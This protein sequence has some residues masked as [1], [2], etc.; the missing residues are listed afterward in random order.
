MNLCR[1]IIILFLIIAVL[2]AFAQDYNESYFDH[3]TKADGLSNNNITGITQDKTGYIWMTTNYGLTRFDGNRF[4]QYHSTDDSLSPASENLTGITWLDDHRLAI[5]TNGLNIINTQTGER[6]NL[7][8]PY[9]RKQYLYKFNMTVGAKGDNKG[10]IYLLTRSGFY[11]FDK[12]YNLV[13]RFDYYSEQQVATE[14][15]FFGGK[16]LELDNRRFLIVSSSGLYAY[17]KEERKIEKMKPHDYPLLDEFLGYPNTAFEFF[18]QKAG[19][20]FIVRPGTD[21]LIYINTML[22][23]KV[24]SNLPFKNPV[25]NISWRS[26]L[27]NVNDT[28]FYI[29]CQF[30]GFYKV[31]FYPESGIIKFN[32]QKFFDAYSC[33]ALLKD[34]DGILWVATNKGLFRQNIQKQNVQFATFPLKPGN[35]VSSIIPSNVFVSQ[36]KIYAG[37]H[38]SG[39]LSLFDKKTFQFEKQIDVATHQHFTVQVNE[40]VPAGKEDILIS[41]SS[42]LY[43]LNQAT[44]KATPVIPTGWFDGEWTEDLYRDK[45]GIIWISASS[46]LF[47][48][49]TNNKTFRLLPVNSQLMLPVRFAEDKDGN[50]WMASHGLQRFNTSAQR[51]DLM[52][53]SF[54]FIKMPDRQVNT[55]LV[56]DENNVWFNSN[57]NGLIAYNITN[58]KFR[59]F[60][61]KDG[62]PDNNIASMIIINKKLWIASFSGLACM[63]LKT[64]EII[65]FG[66]EDGFPDM[67]ISIDTK[68]FYDSL[69]HQLYTCFYNAIVRFN[70]DN[71]LLKNSPPRLFIESVLING[72][73]A[74][75]L[76][77]SDINVSWRNNEM[78]IK[79]GSI[80][81]FDGSN[82]NFAYRI[83]KH[84]TTL[85]QQLGNQPSFSISNLSP[86]THVIQVKCSSLNNKWPEQVKEISV[87]VLP[88]FWMQDW[89]IMLMVL[90]IVAAVYFLVRWRIASIRKKEMEKT[91]IQKLKA[92]DYK[93]QFELEQIS[94]YFSSSL[95]GKKTEAEVLW[96]VTNNLM[97]KMNYED[98]IIYL[99][100]KEKT[101]MVQKAAYG[102]KGKPEIISANVFEVLPGQGIVGHVIETR[103]PVLI[104]D[105]R[106]DERYRIDDAFRL[107]EVCV[108]IIHNNELLGALDSE[109]SQPGYYGE[110]DIKILTTIAT[111]IGNKLKQ[112]ES[113]Q[114]LEVKQQELA[115]INEQL[116]AARLTALQAQMNP[117]FV[118]NALNS[119]KRMI[120]DGDNEKA[121]RYLSKFAQMIRM[122]LEQSKDT[123]VSLEENIRYLNSYLEMEQLRFDETFTYKIIVDENIDV[124]ET[125]FPSL[126]IQPLVE[127]AIWHGLMPAGSDKKIYIKFIQTQNRIVCIIEDNGI[128]IG[129]SESIKQKNKSTHRSVGLENLQKRIKIINEKYDIDCSLEI[130]DLKD[131]D[132]YKSGTKAVLGFN[133]NGF[134]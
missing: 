23:R 120:L 34:K 93:S 121:S 85:W 92:D 122:T 119:I 52:I 26:K 76:P 134:S 28:T 123:F 86:G 13:F 109:H 79:I 6:R 71:I 20:I 94:N 18:Q 124:E 24:V 67:P 107:S 1:A 41:T 40:I 95:F 49:N 17:D 111:L 21:S 50:I 42:L 74:F 128:G 83:F 132:T 101:R 106:K 80:N 10:N 51:F 27:I 8:V 70:P 11:Q 66:K 118:F 110:R 57:N 14:H 4:V 87:V 59:H 44:E 3:Y 25:D 129:M 62:L 60:T 36:N 58:K 16:L 75:Y 37:M 33:N 64:F 38:A 103:K 98:C 78:M 105:T 35:T 56:D 2:P 39:K 130:I 99:W 69:S 47:Q 54:P 61:Y 114:S 45:K 9:H 116:A 43:T 7:F 32:P 113:E 117:H 125:S 112:I 68:L 22:N 65:R 102:P 29:T 30:W 126:M 73:N 131:L 133:M 89:F 96:D 46:S 91:H 84:D 55:L 104:N 5:Y 97:R 53:D 90:I 81:F 12:N 108:P 15:F 115:T 31:N 88:P 127:N 19:N 48:Y 77:A 100:N 72:K 82:Q 63:D